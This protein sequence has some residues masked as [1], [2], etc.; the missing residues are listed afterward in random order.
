[1]INQ[2]SNRV[3]FTERVS[4]LYHNYAG[5]FWLMFAGMFLSTVG[6]SMIW[7]FL[8]LY[9]SK[10]LDAP[11]TAVASLLTL[12]STFALIASFLGG[13]I[14]DR[15]GRKWLMVISLAANGVAYIFLG[16]AVTLQQF[17]ILLS[18][19]GAVNPLYRT[20]ADAM[21]ADLV[22]PAKR[23]DAYALLRMSNNL[24]IAIGP[25]IGGFVATTSYTLAFHFAAAGMISYSMLLAS[26]AHE[27]LPSKQAGAEV[28]PPTKERLAGYPAIL[29]DMRF[30]PFVFTFALVTICAT[31]IWTLMPVHANRNFGVVENVYK[32]IPATNAIMVV[33]FQALVTRIT[34][35]YAALPVLAVGALFYAFG[36][37]GVALA[38]GF[39]GFWL[40]MVIMT[41]GELILV[42]TSSTYV[43]NLAPA[44]K[45]G[46]YMSLYALTW[47]VSAGLGPLFGGFLNDMIGPRAIWIGGLTAGM[48]SAFFFILLSRRPTI[49]EPLPDSAIAAD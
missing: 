41:T 22:P 11:L 46:R 42:P 3:S 40:C 31:L 1:M 38:A 34:K 17:A 14:I 21:L 19:S 47:P 49:P 29:R 10:R 32:W 25:V 27:T 33:L 24:G 2:D 20:A 6:A 13:P 35:R 9:V 48:A 23:P 12:N 18:I 37:G 45:R 44:D 8:M 36:V 43:A 30:S 39:W 28:H 7:P 15:L 4:A 5:Q 16:N 26:F